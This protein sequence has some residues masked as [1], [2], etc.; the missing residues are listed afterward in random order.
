MLKEM[1]FQGETFTLRIKPKKTRFTRRVTS[2]DYENEKFLL[3][4]DLYFRLAVFFA[5][6]HKKRDSSHKQQTIE[7]TDARVHGT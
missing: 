3:R 4:C 1:L 6:I 5:L 7:R 2:T